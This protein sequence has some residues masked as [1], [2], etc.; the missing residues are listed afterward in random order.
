MV[1][2][3]RYI[4]LKVAVIGKKTWGEGGGGVVFSNYSPKFIAQQNTKFW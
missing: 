4:S 2:T 3:K 1:C